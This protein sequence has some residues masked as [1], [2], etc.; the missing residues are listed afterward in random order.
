MAYKCGKCGEVFND[1]PQGIIRCPACAYK[2]FFKVR[3]PVAKK[4]QAK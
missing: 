4:I 2:V 1:L 3:Q